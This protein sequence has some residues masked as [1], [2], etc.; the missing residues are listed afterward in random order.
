M[1]KVQSKVHG[2]NGSTMVRRYTKT[3]SESEDEIRIVVC[4]SSVSV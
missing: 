1:G 4:G 2:R 3:E